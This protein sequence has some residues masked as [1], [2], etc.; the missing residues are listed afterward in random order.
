MAFPIL[1]DFL[2]LTCLVQKAIRETI[3][4][5]AMLRKNI[6]EDSIR[7]DFGKDLEKVQLIC[8]FFESD[9]VMVL[10]FNLF[11]GPYRLSLTPS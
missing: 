6:S 2:A 8:R 1:A 5:S 3:T 9:I 11:S 4:L 7:Y 10:D